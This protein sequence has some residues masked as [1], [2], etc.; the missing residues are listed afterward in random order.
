MKYR[1]EI[2][3]IF[4]LL[5]FFISLGDP[6]VHI[7]AIRRR[8]P[9]LQ[10]P[11]PYACIVDSVP[12]ATQVLMFSNPDGTLDWHNYDFLL[13][14]TKIQYSLVPRVVTFKEVNATGVLGEFK[15]FLAIGM[16][17]QALESMTRQSGLQAVKSCDKITVLKSTD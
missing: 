6:I 17:N 5:L 13:T 12:E 2:G 3:L 7:G 9:D 8:I 16:D 15:W 10:T 11:N 1:F 4:F 14:F